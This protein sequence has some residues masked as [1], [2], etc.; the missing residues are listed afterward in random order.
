MAKALVIRI[1][2]LVAE[3]PRDYVSFNDIVRVPGIYSTVLT[4]EC[5]KASRREAKAKK[6]YT[7]IPVICPLARR[8]GETTASGG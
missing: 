8:G 3:R 2:P 1:S 6:K 4:V 5:E 7:G